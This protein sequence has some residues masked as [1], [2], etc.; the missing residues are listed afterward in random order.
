MNIDH[1]TLP[2]KLQ[3]SRSLF[4]PS[5]PKPFTADEFFS[6]TLPL[7]RHETTKQP[8]DFTPHTQ[9][10]DIQKFLSNWNEHIPVSGECSDKWVHPTGGQSIPTPSTAKTETSLEDITQR[11]RHNATSTAVE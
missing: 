5:L 11:I 2:I 1:Y 4:P 3:N 10:N 6:I 9:K 7:F 8:I